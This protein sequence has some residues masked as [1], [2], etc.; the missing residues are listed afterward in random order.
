[1]P[2]P[3]LTTEPFLSGKVISG[4]GEGKYYMRK[5]QY[6]RQFVRLLGIDPYIG[7]L[8]I[9]LYQKSQDALARIKAERGILVRG[10]AQGKKK[11]GDVACYGAMLMGV[12]CALIAPRLSPYTETAEL[13]APHN[14]RRLL[15]LKNG[16]VVRIAVFVKHA[17]VRR[18]C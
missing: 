10:F 16:S 15:K 3:C 14:L 8:N 5:R 4:K 7:T 9:K 1:M 2:T 11:F 18:G 12:E 6:R 13:I 17:R